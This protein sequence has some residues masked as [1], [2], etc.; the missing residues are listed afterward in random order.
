MKSKATH[1]H[2]SSSYRCALS[3]ILALS[4][5]SACS[6]KVI[7]EYHPDGNLREMLFTGD[8]GLKYRM[9]F[10]YEPKLRNISIQKTGQAGG[11]SLMEMKVRYGANGRIT[12]I[13]RSALLS[14]A[15]ATKDVEYDSFSY[16]KSGEV[17]R[18]ETSYK[19]SFSISKHKTALVTAR[20]QYNAGLISEINVDGGT[21]RSVM[22]LTHAKEE[23][24]SLEYTHSTFNW[25]TKNYQVKKQI[26]FHYDDGVPEKAVDMK[27]NRTITSRAAVAAL[28]ASEEIH[29]PLFKV[30]FGVHYREFLNNAERLLVKGR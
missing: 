6:K 1:R 15:S 8:D 22:K 19:S 17:T 26:V 16:A 27:E 2:F 25:Q 18:I 7:R 30:L 29:M 12:F 20:Y 11:K 13:S 3:L 9:T 23:L 4:L 28:Y 24:R 10:V 5:A 21:F 14:A